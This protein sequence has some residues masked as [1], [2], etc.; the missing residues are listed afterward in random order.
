[1]RGGREG[2]V[3]GCEGR[4]KNDCGGKEGKEVLEYQYMATYLN[5]MI[6]GQPLLFAFGGDHGFELGLQPLAVHRNQTVP[7]SLPQ[8]GQNSPARNR[9]NDDQC[10]LWCS[11]L[12][13]TVARQG[14]VPLVRVR[15]RRGGD[16]RWVVL[17]VAAFWQVVERAKGSHCFWSVGVVVLVGCVCVMCVIEKRK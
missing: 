5:S 14:L 16:L 9:I 10:T 3:G 6:E 15:R 13:G 12:S 1:M 11:I 8:Q 17:L 2:G 7:P 4:R